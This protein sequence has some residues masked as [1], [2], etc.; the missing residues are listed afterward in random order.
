MNKQ[1]IITKISE[2]I[3]PSGPNVEKTLLAVKNNDLI[4]FDGVDTEVETVYEFSQA[5]GFVSLEEKPKIS[6]QEW[7]ELQ[8]FSSTNLAIFFDLESRLA[9]LSR[10]SSKMSAVRGWINNIISSYASNPLPRHVWTDSPHTY[11]ETV[12]EAVTALEAP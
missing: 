12:T 1:Q 9:G 10:S 8:G 6:M 4:L 3:F 2:D 11:S 7:L 5:N